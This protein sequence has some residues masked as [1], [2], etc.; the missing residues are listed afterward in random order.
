MGYPAKP[1]DKIKISPAAKRCQVKTVAGAGDGTN[2][3][4]QHS[5]NSVAAPAP[6]AFEKSATMD[7]YRQL[8]N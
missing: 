6:A 7:W 4:G 5:R 3:H 2:N 1:V 8:L